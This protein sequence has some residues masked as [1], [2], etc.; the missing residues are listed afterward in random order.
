LGLGGRLLGCSLGL[1]G[2]LLG[3]LTGRVGLLRLARL[4]FRIGLSIGGLYL[5]GLR[6]CI[7]AGL[8][9]GLNRLHARRFR[10]L[11]G[12]P[13]YGC[14]G[15]VILL[16]VVVVIGLAQQLA[17]AIHRIGSILFRLCGFRDSHCI[18][19][20]FQA[21]GKVLRH[22]IDRFL[23]RLDLR[24]VNGRRHHLIGQINGSSPAFRFGAGLVLQN[25]FFARLRH[26]KVRFRCDDQ[27]KRLQRHGRMKRAFSVFHDEFTKVRR[28]AFRTDR[29]QNVGQIFEAETVGRRQ[30]LQFHFDLSGSRLGVDVSFAAGL[31]HP[32]G[33]HE[34]NL[35]FA[36]LPVIHRFRGA[37]DPLHGAFARVIV[38]IIVL[39]GE[40]QPGTDQYWKQELDGSHGSPRRPPAASSMGDPPWQG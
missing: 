40:A 33:A 5:S 9:S 12:F 20:L 1:R 14:N 24:C 32:I 15:F 8:F 28:H 38:R 2:L 29:P 36:A 39:L 21:E 11:H 31:R 10:R 23:D 26:R 17:S 22:S 13:S 25:H 37:C 19:R 34:I 3:G 6:F 7:H 4:K 18:S 16:A 27:G 30:I 35:R